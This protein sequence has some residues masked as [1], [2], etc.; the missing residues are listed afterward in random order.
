MGQYKK[1]DTLTWTL[2]LSCFVVFC[3]ALCE[4]LFFGCSLFRDTPAPD[5]FSDGSV[6]ETSLAVV[7]TPNNDVGAV[8]SSTT[9]TLTAMT[10]D[11]DI[12]S[13]MGN[14]FVMSDVRLSSSTKD[15]STAFAVGTL[16][17][18]KETA[19]Y[20][21]TRTHDDNFSQ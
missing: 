19:T 15:A 13:R 2:M 4:I 12:V 8:G 3:L 1:N 6:L 5:T 16:F 9:R 7:G 11:T 14:P 10:E 21:T 18:L 20:A 17:K